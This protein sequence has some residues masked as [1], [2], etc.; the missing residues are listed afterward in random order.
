LKGTLRDDTWE[1][2]KDDSEDLYFFLRKRKEV[3]AYLGML[4][5]FSGPWIRTFELPLY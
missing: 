2:K 4:H 1:I 5:R 3:E